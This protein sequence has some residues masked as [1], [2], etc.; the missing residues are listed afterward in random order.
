MKHNPITEV[1]EARSEPY[2]KGDRLFA[3]GSKLFAEVDKL[4]TEDDKLYTKG[5]ELFA[6]GDKLFA[7][8]V[9]AKHAG[10]IDALN[11]GDMNPEECRT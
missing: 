5:D 6:E 4:H 3:E 9:I 2:A 10:N 7:C 11:D 8:A 1:W